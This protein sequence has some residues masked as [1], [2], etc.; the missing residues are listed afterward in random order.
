M[1]AEVRAVCAGEGACGTVSFAFQ[2]PWAGGHLTT[3]TR[4]TTQSP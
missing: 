1:K 3:W 2:G 4:L